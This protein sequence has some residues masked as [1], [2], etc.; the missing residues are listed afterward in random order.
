MGLFRLE[1]IRL[2]NFMAFED[3]DWIELKPITLMFGR[4]SSGKSAVIRG[5]LFLKQC[6]AQGNESSPL[7]FSGP[8]VDLGSFQNAIH[9]HD[10]SREMSFSF[11]IVL[12]EAAL[13]QRISEW[14][15]QLMSSGMD[16]VVEVANEEIVKHDYALLSYIRGDIGGFELRVGFLNRL[17]QQGFSDGQLSSIHICG[18]ADQQQ[19]Y[20]KQIFTAD[21][22]QQNPPKWRWLTQT[23]E[24]L[25]VGD[26]E[27]QPFQ[28]PRW[29][30]TRAICRNGFIPNLTTDEVA[31]TEETP[32]DWLALDA[33]L[34]LFQDIVFPEFRDLI[35]VPP[36][37]ESSKRY[38]TSDTPLLRGLWGFQQ[39]ETLT[40]ANSWIDSV[41]H[42]SILS[43]KPLKADEGLW[44][45]TIQENLPSIGL[46]LDVNIKDSGSGF[47]Q[48][49]PII[50][51][52]LA[53]S[54]KAMIL[55]EQPELHL[56]PSAQT[57]LMD[58]IIRLRGQDKKI[59]LE[60][61]SDTMLLRTRLRFAESNL[62]QVTEGVLPGKDLSILFVERMT[63]TS[64]MHFLQLDVVGR[65]IQPPAS[66]ATFFA[67][68]I[69]DLMRLSEIQFDQ[70]EEQDDTR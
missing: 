29:E 1:A 24:S 32:T 4:N 20:D 30:T 35:H 23:L 14:Q 62:K 41:A 57:K 51:S 59:L 7:I 28:H 61:H 47:A 52:L 55:V 15:Q 27:Y 38:Y 66:F 50:A 18:L 5:L 53:S 36:L 69:D 26:K 12:D 60:T 16:R 58:L 10:I 31:R 39:Q 25:S 6:L 40:Q 65:F 46:P 56:H 33:L 11:R 42:G 13:K 49:L 19:E 43:I 64:E 70:S 48:A 8:I 2:Q 37:R 44:S 9:R 21:K 68:D 22:F 17:N 67:N 3:T 34:Q 45:I 54:S 63:S